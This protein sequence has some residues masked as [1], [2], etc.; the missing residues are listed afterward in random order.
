MYKGGREFV[1]SPFKA[2]SKTLAKGKHRLPW[3]Y[4]DKVKKKAGADHAP[5]D[6][7]TVNPRLTYTMS[8][9]QDVRQH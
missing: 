9:H 1:K 4:L 7:A 2:I 5:G 6:A 3:N 8:R